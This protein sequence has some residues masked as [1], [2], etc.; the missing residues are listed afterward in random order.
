MAVWMWIRIK[1]YRF[2]LCMSFIPHSQAHLLSQN[3]QVFSSVGSPKA[4]WLRATVKTFSEWHLWKKSKL[5]L[6]KEPRTFP[7]YQASEGTSQEEHLVV[8]FKP[9]EP[10]LSQL[11]EL[12]LVFTLESFFYVTRVALTSVFT[13]ATTEKSK[14]GVIGLPTPVM[15]YPLDNNKCDMFC[16]CCFFD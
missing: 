5:N 9:M 15:S 6:K 13:W 2:V 14:S 3:T 8:G 4:K 16:S 10:N 11:E 12:T 7:C 1:W